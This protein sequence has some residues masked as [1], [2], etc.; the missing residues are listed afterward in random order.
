MTD[1]PTKRV[2]DYASS[3]MEFEGEH[4]A[5][6]DLVNREFTITRIVELSSE[7][8]PYLGVE[9]QGERGAFFFFTSHLVV[10]RKLRQC[11]GHEPLLA[12]I[13]KREPQNGGY[14]F[15]DVE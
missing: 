1:K 2:S 6:S 7:D 4:V 11:I 5:V 3:T 14:S 13:R 10:Y 8:G 15:F 12:T 9:I